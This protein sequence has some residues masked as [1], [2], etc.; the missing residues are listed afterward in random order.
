MLMR[1]LQCFWTS[2]LIICFIDSFTPRM[3]PQSIAYLLSG[4]A[5]TYWILD[6]KGEV[7]SIWVLWT[8]GLQECKG[9]V[10]FENKRGSNRFW[11]GSKKLNFF[12]GASL[13]PIHLPWKL[14]GGG[15]MS[16]V[17]RRV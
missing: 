7:Q 16:P 12:L 13:I 10:F 2:E 11:S 5:D 17:G 8:S 4:S 14:I 1:I 15:L 6:L 9:N 3:K